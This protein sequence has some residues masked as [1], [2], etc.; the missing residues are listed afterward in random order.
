MSNSNTTSQPI[1]PMD[2]LQS[3]GDQAKLGGAS[4]MVATAALKDHD[5][6]QMMMEA[7]STPADQIK[8][9]LQILLTVVV[10]DS[11]SIRESRNEQVIRDG[12]NAYFQSQAEGPQAKGILVSIVYLNGTVLMPYMP[13]S[14]V[15]KLDD[16][17]YQ[18]TGRTPLYDKASAVLPMVMM[19]AEKIEAQTGAR[20]ITW[21]MFVT[22]G[23]DW[24]SVKFTAA[25]V[26]N[27]VHDMHKDEGKHIV[28]GMG[29]GSHF[30]WKTIFG[31]MGIADQWIL[32][33]GDTPH[34]MRA[35]F[36]NAS[37]STKQALSQVVGHGFSQQAM[38]GG[39][40]NP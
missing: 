23:Q 27:L 8:P 19:E 25:D 13:L 7:L 33:S 2:L 14:E 30:D 20:V 9:R 5:L 31:E 22:D 12:V 29:I 17:N 38:A 3:V 18:A 21:T 40:G 24:R 39:F 28:A 16:Q 35:A 32:T 26:A 6:G 11:Y 10:D 4:M 37:R 34:A 36:D 15:V 1:D